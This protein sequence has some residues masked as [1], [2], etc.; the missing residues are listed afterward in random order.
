[1]SEEVKSDVEQLADVVKSTVAEATADTVKSAD[2]EGYAKADAIPSVDG[3][4]SEES[5]AEVKAENAELKSQV[6]ALEAVVKSAPAV[7][8]GGNVDTGFSWASSDITTKATVDLSEEMKAFTGTGSSS[9]VNN[10]PTAASRVYHAMQQRNPLRMV[11]MVMPTSAGSVNLPAVTGITAA[12]ENT[13][14]NSINIGS[15]HAG[16]LNGTTN[17]IPQNWVSRTAFSDPA[18]EDLPGLDT[19]IASF[20][21]QEIGVAEATDMVSQLNGATVS[22]VNTGVAGGMPTSIDAWADLAADLSSAYKMNAKWMMSRQALASLRSLTQ[23]GGG[24]LVIDPSNGTFRLW[25]AEI[26]I[27]DHFDAGTTAGHN[28][29]YYGDFSA[30]T[31]IVARKEMS[32]DRNDYTIPGAVYF[33]GCMRSRGVVWDAAALRRFNVGA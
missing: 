28:P 10:T 20:M 8:K 11:S 17:V 29:V 32:I 1:M 12:V 23:S 19:M 13:V 26:I 3:L 6:E 33:Y 22:E 14:P 16:T 25:D 2:L 27:N 30:G 9:Q 4:A 24:D 7:I 18:L 5:V 31:I 15:G 21:G